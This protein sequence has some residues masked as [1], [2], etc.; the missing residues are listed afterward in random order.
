VKQVDLNAINSSQAVPAKRSDSVRETTGNTPTSSVPPATDQVKVSERAEKI[1][2]LVE[3]AK[4]LPDVRQERVEELRQLIESGK[5]NV[6]SQ[7]IAA[8]IISDEQ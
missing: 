4:A 8:A 1:G 5:Y 3:K 7:Q 2:Q 6:S